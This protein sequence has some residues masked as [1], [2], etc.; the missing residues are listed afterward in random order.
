MNRGEWHGAALARGRRRIAR[1]WHRTCM[2]GLWLALAAWLASPAPCAAALPA[3]QAPGSAAAFRERPHFAVE[4]QRIKRTVRIDGTLADG[5]WDPFYT[6]DQGPIHGTVYCNWDDDYLYLAART[7]QPCTVLFDV[8]T[9]GDGWL[10]GADNLEVVVGS[11]QGSGPPPVTARLLDAASNKDTPA[12]VDRSADVRSLLVAAR[13]SNDRQVVELA[14][15]KSTASLVLRAGATLGL[16]AEF[17][18]ADA[19]GTYQPTAPFE[20]HLLLDATLV[21]ARV[22]PA[23]GITA[24]LTLSDEKCIPGENLFATV[25]LTN[26][27]DLPV[28]VRSITWRGDGRSANAVNSLREVAV[29]ELPALKSVKL[30]YKTTLPPTLPLDSYTLNVAAELPDGRQVQAE[31]SFA[32]VE[33]LQVQMSS[34]PQPLIVSGQTKLNLIVDVH[35]AVPNGMRGEVELLG[36]PA[37]W[38]LDGASKRS[39]WIDREDARHAVRYGVKVPAE[40]L[41][42]D[43]PI[44]AVVR[45]HGQEWRAHTVVH[46]V[47]GGGSAVPA[48]AAPAG[49]HTGP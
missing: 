27:T 46:A 22:Q 49:A 5:E 32:V 3:P 9:G 14:I 45:W 24:H 11:P 38:T 35:S 34:A 15:P 18:P 36:L 44:D 19:F 4:P 39:L 29:P 13:V 8:D 43:Y 6:I 26:Q 16:R 30:T 23:E 28:A 25:I 31:A 20:P 48:A 42:G 12:W 40:T 7:E 21:D 1:G 2:P 37:Q 41:A 17:L 10:R 47:H 33:P